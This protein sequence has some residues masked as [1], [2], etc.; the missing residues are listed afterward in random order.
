MTEKEYIKLLKNCLKDLGYSDNEVS[1]V[2]KKSY[3]IG[4][5]LLI[6]Q[7]IARQAFLKDRNTDNIRQFRH[8]Y[9]QLNDGIELA[10]V[11]L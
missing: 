4:T 9:M 8:V 10:N 6:E 3:D 7:L 5:V 11:E 2:I 1:V